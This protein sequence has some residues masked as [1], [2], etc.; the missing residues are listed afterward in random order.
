MP[1]TPERFIYHPVSG[2][3]G[4]SR[5]YIGEGKDEIMSRISVPLLVLFL[6]LSIITFYPQEPVEAGPTYITATTLNSNTTWNQS[7]SPYIIT[8]NLTVPAGIWLRILPGVEVRFNP[9]IRLWIYGA[10]YAIG[11]ESDSITFTSNKTDPAP[12]N[13]ATI[14]IEEEANDT[15]SEISRTIIEYSVIGISAEGS[16]PIITNNIIRNTLSKAISLEESEAYIENNNIFNSSSK[17]IDGEF[18]NPIIENNTIANCTYYGMKFY[19]SSPILK[20]NVISDGLTGIELKDSIAQIDS[21]QISDTKYGVEMDNSD[22]VSINNTTLSYNDYGLYCVDTDTICVNNSILSQN[23]KAVYAL[24]S[25]IYI[26]NS[27]ISNSQELDFI[28]K[29]TSMAQVTNSNFDSNLIQIQDQSYIDVL[30][31]LSVRVESEMGSPYNG[32]IVDI[33]DNSELKSIQYT[34]EI[35]TTHLILLMDRRI[36]DGGAVEENIT[37]VN[38]SFQDKFF[39]DNPRDVDMSMSHTEIFIRENQLPE[40]AISTPNNMARLNST[41]IING[42]SSDLDGNVTS[43]L[44]QI[45]GETWQPVDNT[46]TNWSTWGYSW[47][48][49]SFSEGYY[50]ITAKATDNENAFSTIDIVVIVDNYP[51]SLPTADI[52]DPIEGEE[53]NKTVVITG[54]S[55]DSD[56]VVHTVEIKIDDGPW[57]N[58]IKLTTDWSTWSFNWD[59]SLYS[60]GIHKIKARVIDDEEAKSIPVEIEVEVNNVGNTPPSVNVVSH[61]SGEEVDGP[62]FIRGESSDEDGNVN[63]VELQIDE[64]AWQL[65]TDTGMNYTTWEFNWDTTLYPNGAHNILIRA[66]DNELATSNIYPLGLIVNNGGNMP[67]TIQITYPSEEEE[68]SGFVMINGI[69][70]DSDGTIDTVQIRVDDGTWIN[71]SEVATQWHTWNFSLDTVLYPNGVHIISARAIDDEISYS[72]IDSISLIFNNGGNMPPVVHI[73]SHNSGEKALGTVIIKGISLDRDGFVHKVSIRIDDGPWLSATEIIADWQAWNYTW[74]TT[75]YANGL[76]TVNARCADNTSAESAVHSVTLTVDNGGNMPPMIDITSPSNGDVVKGTIMIRGISVDPE[77]EIG[78]IEI[79]IDNGSW[80]EVNNVLPDWTQWDFDL[81]T[82]DYPNGDLVIRVK[83]TDNTESWASDA[84]LITID[85]EKITVEPEDEASFPWTFVVIFAFLIIIIILVTIILLSF[86]RLGKIEK[87][88]DDI[89]KQIPRKKKKKIRKKKVKTVAEKAP[90]V[91]E[92]VKPVED[93]DF[94]E[95]IDKLLEE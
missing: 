25:S 84:I 50:T 9:D 71:A 27:S 58:A 24:N 57:Q 93:D 41:C 15:A 62:V 47:N 36:V 61:N 72:S 83:V 53:V 46:G 29:E 92:T 31:Y 13:W 87:K 49:T 76:H 32:S 23:N 43:V 18:S 79:Q 48:T 55:S 22:N 70:T 74:D 75:L 28:L 12:G 1:Y 44:L 33:Y 4:N 73:T 66:T 8:D 65:V 30:N 56:G 14:R 45:D 35:G 5:N 85:N 17:G 11:N 64:G 94:Y 52:T 34:D 89:Q 82:T 63:V 77:G 7:G 19:K 54:T 68:V 10:L 90:S 60:D 80:Q 67:P 91:K 69:S 59:S 6:L 88:M 86:K 42:T 3:Q 81:D 51:N 21:T 2:L 37:L 20:N 95:K 26:H 16:S 40:I 78:A 39:I 38:V